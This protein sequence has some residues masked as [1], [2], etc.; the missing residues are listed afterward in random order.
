[1]PRKKVLKRRP[2]YKPNDEDR[3]TVEMMSAIG[4][5]Q[6]NIARCVGGGIDVKTL[7]KYYR[8]E[9]DTAWV[10]A[11]T[12]VGGAMYNKAVGGDVPAQKYWLG[13]RAGW[14]ET[15]VNEHVG[16]DGEDLKWIVE[17]VHAKTQD[18]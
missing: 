1:M 8:E 2:P 7:T 16:K 12:K 4:T 17:V 3:R 13:C 11:N 10:K 15:N 5:T 14:K 18:K 6:A 9:I